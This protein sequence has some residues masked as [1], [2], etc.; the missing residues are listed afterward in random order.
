MSSRCGAPGWRREETQP[1]AWG[2]TPKRSLS[3]PASTAPRPRK[4]RSKEFERGTRPLRFSGAKRSAVETSSREF[5]VASIRGPIPPRGPFDFAQSRLCAHNSVAHTDG[6]YDK[7]VTGKDQRGVMARRP[8]ADEAI[9]DCPGLRLPRQPPAGSQGHARHLPQ[10]CRTP[11]G[12]T[13]AGKS[14]KPCLAQGTLSP[15]SGFN[16]RQPVA[17]MSRRRIYER[18]SQ[19]PHVPPA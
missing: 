5:D 17:R 2:A 12:R 11:H 6:V 14:L 16:E 13:A 18:A 19:S 8:P 15:W 9:L 3:V 7:E 4:T 1:C 10:I